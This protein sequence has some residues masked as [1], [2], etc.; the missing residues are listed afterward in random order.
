[1]SFGT[2]I[3]WVYIAGYAAAYFYI[4]HLVKGDPKFKDVHPL[5][6]LSDEAV[7]A[8]GGLF[9]WAIL[10]AVLFRRIYLFIRKIKGHLIILNV[11]FTLWKIEQKSK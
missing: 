8:F 11:K 10:V 2:I 9:S 5:K 7:C 3:L 1:M 4:R 6:Y